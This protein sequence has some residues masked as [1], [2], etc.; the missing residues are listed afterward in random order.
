MSQEWLDF[1]SIRGVC[2]VSACCERLEET[3]EAK[4]LHFHTRGAS[5]V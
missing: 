4:D 3:Q 2:H 1:A 5:Q